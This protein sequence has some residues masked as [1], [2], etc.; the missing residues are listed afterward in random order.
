MKFI[1]QLITLPK[2]FLFA[3]FCCVLST[4]AASQSGKFV[5]SQRLFFEE[6]KQLCGRSFDGKS[7]FP[8]NKEDSFYGKKLVMEVRDCSSREIKVPFSVGEDR[9]RTWILS[10]N[11]G[12]LLF[13]HDHRHLDGTP[14]DLTMYGGYADG[15]GGQYSQSFP[16]DD[17]T[18]IMVPKGKTN[19]WHLTIDINN[20]EFIYYLERHNKPRFKAVFKLTD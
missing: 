9:S 20:N 4:N 16:A 5:D 8:S 10:I 18:K 6:F 15:K 13:K 1:H 12:R 17:E 7:T 3:G 2:L 14:D 19:V 11:K